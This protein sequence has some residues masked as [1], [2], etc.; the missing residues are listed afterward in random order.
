MACHYNTSLTTNSN[1][2]HLR[3]SQQSLTAGTNSVVPNYDTP[4]KVT[5]PVPSEIPRARGLNSTSNYGGNLRIR[6]TDKEYDLVFDEALRLGVTPSN[7]CRWSIVQT[8]LALRDHRELNSKDD[9]AEKP[10]TVE[11]FG[12]RL[13]EV[14]PEQE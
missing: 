10:D 5:I 2:T 9:T 14:E 12:V 8:A 1:A 7:F 3:I 13:K 11:A 6:C 4:I